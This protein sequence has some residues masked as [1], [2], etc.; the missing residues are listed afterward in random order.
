MFRNN[1]DSDTTTFSPQGRLFQVEYAQA[2][3][4]QGSIVVGAVSKSHAVLVALKRQAEELSSYQKKIIQIDSHLGIA[5]SGLAADARVLS[6]FMKQQSMASHMTYD[7]PISIA[8]ISVRLCDRAQTH[9]QHAGSRPYGVGL[10]IAGVD[11]KGPHLFEFQPSGDAQEMVAAS[12]GARSQ[13]ARTFLEDQVKEFESMDEATL[14]T[15][16]LRALIRSQPEDKVLSYDNTSIGVV[17]L[18]KSFKLLEGEEIL[19]HVKRAYRLEGRAPEEYSE[20]A[21]EGGSME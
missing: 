11:G 4:G 18:E 6:N 1:Y 5:L 15:Y 3:V 7:R 10:L 9:T 20:N 12:I 17:G 2:A 8:D 19:E 13:A 14:I 16:T 21:D